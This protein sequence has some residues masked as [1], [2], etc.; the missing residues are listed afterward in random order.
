MEKLL[1]IVQICGLTQRHDLPDWVRNNI[2]TL[3]GQGFVIGGKQFDWYDYVVRVEFRGVK[4]MTR[5]D[6]NTM[7]HNGNI[8]NS[9]ERSCK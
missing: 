6:I 4:G 5:E 3:G 8:V 9:I 7:A 2:T 1:D